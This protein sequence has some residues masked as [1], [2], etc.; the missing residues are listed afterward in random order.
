MLSRE[1]VQRETAVCVVTKGTDFVLL[2][3]RLNLDCGYVLLVNRAEAE[4]KH[5]SPEIVILTFLL[6][7]LA[8]VLWLEQSGFD[9]SSNTWYWTLKGKKNIV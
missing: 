2:N 3:F 1:T 7:T 9:L 5:L 8:C 6:E 4:M